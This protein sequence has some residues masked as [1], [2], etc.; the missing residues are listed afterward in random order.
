MK[1]L[2]IALTASLVVLLGANALVAE[3]FDSLALV[4]RS[5]AVSK[6]PGCAL[7]GEVSLPIEL[8]AGPEF[9]FGFSNCP[10]YH[11]CICHCQQ[12]AVCCNNGGGQNCLEEELECMDVCVAMLGPEE[13]CENTQC[14]IDP[15][16]NFP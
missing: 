5:V 14:S 15:F 4:D 12:K 8:A 10:R 7:D 6:P 2:W 16:C 3:S 13:Q 9:G 1:R 11:R